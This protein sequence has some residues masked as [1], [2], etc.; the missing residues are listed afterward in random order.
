[1]TPQ[2]DSLV[3]RSPRLLSTGRISRADSPGSSRHP[4]HARISRRILALVMALTASLLSGGGLH[5]QQAP[6]PWPTDDPGEGASNN[7]SQPSRQDGYGQPQY[8]QPQYA[9]PGPQQGYDPNQ[10]Y[11]Q[12][13]VLQQPQGFSADQLEQMVAPIALYPDNLVSIVLA[14]ST[15]PAQVAEASQWLR[16]QGSAAPEQIAA[17]ANAQ[18]GWDPAVKALTAFPQVLDQLAQN[19]QWTTDLG[20]AYYNQPQDVMQ[21]V[22]VMRSRAQAAGNLQSTPQQQVTADQG[23]IELAP[24]SPQMVYVPTYNPWVI[25][26]TPVPQY[27]GYNWAGAVGS[28]IGGA[29]IQWGPGIA[30]QAFAP[31]GWIGWGLDWFAHAVLFNHGYY[32]TH[33]Y[34]V[35]DWGF[36]HGGPRGFRGWERANFR[37]GRGWGREDFLRAGNRG[38]GYGRFGNDRIAHGGFNR[39]GEFSRG[40]NSNQSSAFNRPDPHFGNDRIA[41]GGYRSL[42]STYGRSGLPQQAYNHEP[43]S[44]AGTSPG[45]SGRP[46]SG[47]MHNY[48][49][50]YGPGYG[51]GRYGSSYGSGTYSRP[52]PA[53]PARTGSGY[54]APAYRSSVSPTS[55]WSGRY[56][57]GQA[58]RVYGY[59]GPGLAQSRSG[60]GNEHVAGGFR[61]SGGSHSPWGG[62]S[63]SGSGSY[64]APSASHFG[65]GGGG[66]FSGGGHSGGGHSGSSHGKRR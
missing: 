44:Y 1:M 14:A 40:Q 9:Q 43:Q 47:A 18:T 39:S 56:S 24:P 8:Q 63:H 2:I 66:H 3:S 13:Q 52:S 33:S 62:G 12:P 29:F 57:S 37:D 23:N 22:Q 19:L 64:K 42:G 30:L 60:I 59:G 51:S 4:D 28:F 35:H 6:D 7:Q 46:Q 50:V 54:S 31:F 27:P 5:A 41:G 45:Y 61:M 16:M 49:S 65:G 25:Y 38:Q 55:P 36:A 26:G 48:G 58:G 21:T 34:Q 10:P 20:N 17:A 11:P 15:Y 32:C 53:Y